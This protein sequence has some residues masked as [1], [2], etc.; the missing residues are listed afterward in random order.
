MPVVRIENAKLITKAMEK[1][2]VRSVNK[3]VAKAKTAASRH[4]RTIYNIKARD[5]NPLIRKW[6]AN[7]NHPS[8]GFYISSRQ[9]LKLLHFQAKDIHPHGVKVKILKQRGTK[10]LKHAFIAQMPSG[11][12]NVFQGT[13]KYGIAKKGRYQGKRREKIKSLYSVDPVTMFETKA[14]EVVEKTLRETFFKVFENQL[15][16]EL[17]R[18]AS[19]KVT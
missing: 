9:G 15:D 2:I 10:N 13:G 7:K 4:V 6:N 3:A 16:Y 8:G 19:I 1:A 17:D 11:H 18:I 5:L 12:V 14:V